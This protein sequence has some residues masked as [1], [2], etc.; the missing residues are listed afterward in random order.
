MSDEIV[1]VKTTEELIKEGRISACEISANPEYFQN[2]VALMF[3]TANAAR[4][5]VL[6]V[7]FPRIGEEK[8]R[9]I[10]ITAVYRN[11][12]ADILTSIMGLRETWLMFKKEDYESMIK[13]V[14]E[15]S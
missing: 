15:K 3:V 6:D 13:P 9:S 14:M 2:N 11:R 4:R 7:L 10:F 1:E 5:Y 12:A 8:L